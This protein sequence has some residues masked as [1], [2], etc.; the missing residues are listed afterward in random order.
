MKKGPKLRAAKQPKKLPAP[1]T[2]LAYEDLMWDY[3]S[4]L[5]SEIFD[6]LAC[7]PPAPE[8]WATV[9]GAAVFYASTR[10]AKAAKRLYKRTT[11]PVL[12]RLRKITWR[13]SQKQAT[14]DAMLLW[15][16]LLAQQSALYP[17]ASVAQLWVLIRDALRELRY[18][19]SVVEADG[20]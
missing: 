7:R 12:R 8:F 3:A 4:P 16:A 18:E 10:A 11:A 6:E 15:G 17:E 20:C 1:S 19:F 5:A 2:G 13:R 9:S 14:Q